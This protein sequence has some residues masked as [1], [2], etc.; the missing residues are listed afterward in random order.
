MLLLVALCSAYNRPRFLCSGPLHCGALRAAGTP[1]PSCLSLHRGQNPIGSAARAGDRQPWGR[2]MGFS[3]PCFG[4]HSH[5][6]QHCIL[7]M[8][9]CSLRKMH[10]KE[11]REESGLYAEIL[12]PAS[13]NHLKNHLKSHPNPLFPAIAGL[14]KKHPSPGAHRAAG[15]QHTP[16][17]HREPGQGWPH[18]AIPSHLRGSCSLPPAKC[19][20]CGL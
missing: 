3:H 11:K 4:G 14:L 12:E 16:C 13:P 19:D 2:A 20:N 1:S 7:R 10:L 5:L 9:E 17:C 6:S 15:A 18:I 8:L